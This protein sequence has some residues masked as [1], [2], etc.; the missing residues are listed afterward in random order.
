MIPFY[1]PWS[2]QPSIELSHLPGSPRIFAFGLIVMTTMVLGPM[3]S[4]FV[5]KQRGHKRAEVLI[6]SFLAILAGFPSAH[7]VLMLFYFPDRVLDDPFELFRVLNGMASFGGFAGGALAIVFFLR[8]KGFNVRA[9]LDTFTIA[10]LPIWTLARLG[11]TMAHDHP[12]DST[13]FFLAFDHPRL[14]PIHDLGFYE[15]ILSAF[16]TIILYF[17][18]FS[19]RSFGPNGALTAGVCILYSIFRFGIDELQSAT[20]RILIFKPTQW[21]ALVFLLVGL[22]FGWKVLKDR[23]A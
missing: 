8:L 17:W 14:G 20:E 16:L 11:C 18:L 2:E 13:T 10:L 15:F 23:K 5:A 7:L 12:G 21:L 6:A 3:M 1:L 4:S 22:V 19:K 9:Y